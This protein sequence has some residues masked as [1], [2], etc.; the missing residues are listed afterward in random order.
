MLVAVGLALVLAVGGVFSFLFGVV[1]SSEGSVELAQ[2]LSFLV[3]GIVWIAAAVLVISLRGDYRRVRE[4]PWAWTAIIGGLVLLPVTTFFQALLGSG[5]ENGSLEWTVRLLVGMGIQVVLFVIVLRGIRAVAVSPGNLRLPGD[6]ARRVTTGQTI[7]GHD[8]DNVQD[9]A[10][11]RWHWLISAD[12]SPRPPKIV[13]AAIAE[14]VSGVVIV[15]WLA[16]LLGFNEVGVIWG[17]LMVLAG[18]G[19]YAQI[20][21][22]RIASAF[23][24]TVAALWCLFVLGIAGVASPLVLA[25]LVLVIATG[26]LVL[27]GNGWLGRL[28]EWIPWRI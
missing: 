27:I 14:I 4:A 12:P 20:G 2:R 21:A 1:G 16:G 7:T 9:A 5:Q 13:V 8:L 19:L 28:V 18:I 26:V 15:L 17:T 3:H 22:A 10:S 25:A 23:L 11:R 6:I 24:S